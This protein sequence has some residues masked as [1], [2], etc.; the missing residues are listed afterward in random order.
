MIVTRFNP[1]SNG[2]LHLGHVYM[3]LI[4]EAFAEDG[5][6]IVRWDDSHPRR[7]RDM[8]RE[9]TDNIRRGQ[10]EDMEWLGFKPY[11]YIKQSDIIDEARELAASFGVTMKDE[12]PVKLARLIGSDYDVLTYPLTPALTS[13][14]VIMD[15]AIG[16]THLIRGIDLM[17]EYSLYQYFCRLFN[18]PQPEHIYLPRLRWRN[19][20]M[21]K[22]LGARSVCNMRNE[23]YTPQDVRDIVA[24]ACLRSPGNG[25]TLGNI[26]GVPCL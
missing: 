21:S 6:F 4:N 7:I 12:E 1:S 17:T 13:E 25:W 19:G 24:R 20:D 16:T 2:P 3:A 26:K 5:R 8:G 14:K 10:R 15:H 23:G 18:L 11:A 9:R 22:T